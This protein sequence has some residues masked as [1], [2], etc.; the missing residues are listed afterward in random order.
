MKHR[1]LIFIGLLCTMPVVVHGGVVD[2]V[3]D[4]VS[5]MTSGGHRT[6]RVFDD[7]G[8][9]IDNPTQKQ[10]E[11]YETKVENW[12]RDG[13]APSWYGTNTVSYSENTK[14]DRDE[15][16][17]L[18]SS[19]ITKVV[20]MKDLCQQK[21][22]GT[23]SNTSNE[24][25]CEYFSPV[26]GI[27]DTHAYNKGVGVIQPAT[28]DDIDNIREVVSMKVTVISQQMYKQ[29]QYLSATLQ[30]L[31]TQLEKNVLTAKLQMAGAQSDGSNGSS[32]GGSNARSNASDYRWLS[33]ASNCWASNDKSSAYSCL[34]TNI[35]LIQSTVQKDKRNAIS[36]L[37]DAIAFAKTWD[38]DVTANPTCTTMSNND[39][40]NFKLST[41]ARPDAVIKCANAL[42]QALLKHKDDEEKARYATPQI[43][44]PK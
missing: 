22:G 44:Y 5:D 42:R 35:G 19:M 2:T 24:E 40:N 4:A 28:Q 7:N 14:E 9:V 21:L 27:C 34:Q 8:N 15:S 18:Y 31:K 37:E 20:R 32:G 16:R 38:I 33:G 26:Y 30:R 43:I 36:Q 17:T 10:R 12:N 11:E 3:M 23:T 25:N 6:K 1:Y 39:P 29:Y 13:N 41:S